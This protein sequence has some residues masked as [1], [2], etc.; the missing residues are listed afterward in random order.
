MPI[1]MFA[2]DAAVYGAQLQLMGKSSSIDFMCDPPPPITPRVRSPPPLPLFP[3]YRGLFL[4]R[5]PTSKA[6]LTA[7]CDDDGP[8]V[9]ALYPN[10]IDYSAISSNMSILFGG[11]GPCSGAL[12]LRT[13]CAA[14]TKHVEPRFWCRYSGTGGAT[15]VGPVDATLEVHKVEGVTLSIRTSASCA[16]PS[17]SEL[18]SVGGYDGVSGVFNVNMSL[19][20]YES[21]ADPM[22]FRGFE[23][24]NTL[25]FVNWPTPPQPPSVPPPPSAPPPPLPP[26]DP[27]SPPPPPPSCHGLFYA[28]PK[29]ASG[30]EATDAGKVYCDMLPD[31]SG[32][33][34][35][36]WTVVFTHCQNGGGDVRNP[37]HSMPIIPG[38]TRGVTSLEYDKVKSLMKPT[39][40]RFHSTFKSGPGYIFS[41]D[42][43]TAS[44]NPLKNL[45]DGITDSAS[46]QLVQLGAALAGSS[47]DDCDLMIQDNNG[48]GSEEHDQ[49]TIGCSASSVWSSTGMRWGQIDGLS[50]YNGISHLGKESWDHS[51]MTSDGCLL[52]SVK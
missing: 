45:L 20:Y 22:P 8:A 27:P 47:G 28:D 30:V 33:A 26:P 10:S 23:G 41:W 24:R 34:K 44:T 37:S 11:M 17:L 40:V 21:S 5:A 52:V 14:D 31:A 9:L 29:T 6:S 18:T 16:L 35:G 36:G 42:T 19:V 15:Q 7:S 25:H 50:N 46:S 48:G 32:F 1:I 4:R 39:H 12:T 43:I 3:P 49:Q 51:A 2:L 38:T 13:P